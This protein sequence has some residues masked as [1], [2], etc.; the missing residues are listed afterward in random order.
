V[1]FGNISDTL[2]VTSVSW[3]NIPVTL[4]QSLVYAG[5]VAWVAGRMELQTRTRPPEAVPDSP[6]V[7]AT[8]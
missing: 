3:W 1:A 7:S 2:N 5:L 8:V 6:V 4:T